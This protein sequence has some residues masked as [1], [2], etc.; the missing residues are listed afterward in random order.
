VEEEAEEEMMEKAK[1]VGVGVGL[2]ETKRIVC[3]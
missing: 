3:S 1:V 2:G